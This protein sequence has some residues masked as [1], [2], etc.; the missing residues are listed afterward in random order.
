MNTITHKEFIEGYAARKFSVL[1]NKNKAG[2]FIL[3][4]LAD[5]HNKPAYYFWSWLGIIMVLPASI[6]LFIISWK[7]SIFSFI[8]GLF[9]IT[10]SKKSSTQFVLQNMI[11]D[12][13]FF[14]Y[15]LLH[16][17]AKIIGEQGEEFKSQFITKMEL[18]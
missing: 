10:A 17:G 14:E 7:Y 13:D 5:K 6:G 1:I 11:D 15:V 8:C 18:K 9:I 16:Q 4:K 12:E 3:S 2:D